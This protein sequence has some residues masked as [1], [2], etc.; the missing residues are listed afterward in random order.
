MPSRTRAIATIFASALATLALLCTACTSRTA[1]A[2]HQ[3]AMVKEA[4]ASAADICAK[5][6]AVTQAYLEAG[7]QQV[8][9]EQKVAMDI[10]CDSAKTD[11]QYGLLTDASGKTSIAEPDNMD[12]MPDNAALPSAHVPDDTRSAGSSGSPCSK[13]GERC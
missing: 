11:E 7:D 3:L 5:A 8:Y 2:E 9:E 12:A 10:T 6:Q 1:A 13:A 4:H